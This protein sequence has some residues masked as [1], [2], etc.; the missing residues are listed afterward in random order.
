ML[1]ILEHPSRGYIGRKESFHPGQPDRVRNPQ[2]ADNTL[3]RVKWFIAML[4][5]AIPLA[6]LLSLFTL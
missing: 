1:S 2:Q 4:L 5:L 3:D 6:H